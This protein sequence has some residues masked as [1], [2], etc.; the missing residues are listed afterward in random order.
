[1]GA[2][3]P[4]SRALNSCL[5]NL[6]LI[7]SNQTIRSTPRLSSFPTVNA[8]RL[9]ISRGEK[10]RESS[11]LLSNRSDN[12]RTPLS[13]NSQPASFGNK[14]NRSTL[15]PTSGKEPLSSKILITTI[16]ITIISSSS[17]LLYRSSNASSDGVGDYP[18]EVKDLLRKGLNAQIRYNQINQSSNYFKSAYELSKKIYLDVSYERDDCH[19]DLIK[20]SGIGIRWAESFERLG[21]IDQSIEIYERVFED[22]LD[23]R[24]RNGFDYGLEKHHLLVRFRAIQVS[25]KLADLI[26][27]ILFDNDNEER[28]DRVGIEKRRRLIK[29]RSIDESIINEK[30]LESYLS[31]SVEEVL[32]LSMDLSSRSSKVNNQNQS[33]GPSGEEQD[34]GY[35]SQVKRGSLIEVLPDWISREEV[36]TCFE[37]LGEFYDRKGKFEYALPLYLNALSIILPSSKLSGKHAST[38]DGRGNRFFLD[39]KVTIR[40]RCHG[41]ILMNRISRSIYEDLMKRQRLDRKKIHQS[42][43]IDLEHD[44]EEDIRRINDDEKEILEGVIRWTNGSIQLS[45]STI[46][47]F[48]KDESKMFYGLKKNLRKFLHRRGSSLQYDDEEDIKECESVFRVSNINLEEINK[49]RN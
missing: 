42:G 47:S 32:R 44:R 48:R 22:L 31:F 24:R 25:Q 49:T 35:S 46:E 36:G 38:G 10:V 6:S 14:R 29:G 8:Q 41:S 17:Y 5:N 4:S 28:G 40:D 39:K 21:L 23:E 33:S 26:S 43:D 20:I 18:K 2:L 7:I 27:Q 37:R 45:R 13:I 1:M 19:L 3:I 16:I 9:V 11:L 34:K 30:R 15:Q 12:Y